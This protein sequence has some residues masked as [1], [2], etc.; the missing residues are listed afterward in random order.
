MLQK[1]QRLA[2][3]NHFTTLRSIKNRL[4]NN[5]PMKPTFHVSTIARHLDNQLIS[6]KKVGKDS[7]VYNLPSVQF[8]S[9]QR[10]KQWLT[11]LPINANLTYV[12]VDE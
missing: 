5:L 9:K 7:N 3:E 6:F 2:R 11:Q 10:E 1:I 8:A 12:R 4:R